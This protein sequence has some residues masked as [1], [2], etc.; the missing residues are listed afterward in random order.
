LSADR[1]A[2]VVYNLALGTGTTWDEYRKDFVDGSVNVA[3]AC[4]RHRVRR[5]IFASSTAAL[6]LGR[7]ERI[8]ESM[9]VDPKPHLRNF[10][11]RGKIEA[12]RALMDMHTK[13][14]LPVVILRP[15]LVVGPGGNL[16]HGGLGRWVTDNCLLGYGPG[17]HPQPFV[18][19]QDV[20]RAFLVA[21]DLPGIEGMAFTLAG[22]IR[23]S[24]AE[25]VGLVAERSKRN[26][27]LYPQSNL[28]RMAVY[29]AKWALRRL[30][31][32]SRTPRKTYWEIKS[33][34]MFA[35]IDSSA[36]K[37][38]LGWKATDNY[39]VFLREAIDTHLGP[40]HPGDFRLVRPAQEG[41][42][43][44]DRARWAAGCIHTA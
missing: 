6:Y 8:D 29:T 20:A 12:E 42:S 17:T 38:I 32:K 10:Y 18:L 34:S 23:P 35:E 15:A 5:L 9:G 43:R 27:R 11:S 39:D 3:N 19:V 13:V 31:W 24:V 1:Q 22:D 28:K 21:K 37:R 2:W 16:C 25:Y 14:Q 30:L 44:L 40:I 41:E 26:F 33:D 7:K 36:A 4:Q